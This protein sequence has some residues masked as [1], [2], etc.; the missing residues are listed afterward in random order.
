MIALV[1]L[2]W[3]P[4]G[5]A[6]VRDFCRS[7]DAHPAGAEHELVIALNGL[8]APGGGGEAFRLSLE[9]E[10][11]QIPHR[12]SVLRRP[13]LDL[14]AYGILARELESPRLCFLNSYS[15]ILADGWL[16]MLDKALS[17]PGVGLA[18]ATGSW[19]SQS[20]WRRGMRRYWLYQIL[21]L[22]RDRR[23]Y[24][25]F[26]NPHPRT[27]GFMIERETLLELGLEGVRDK[28][29]AYMLESGRS[30]IA[31]TLAGRGLTCVVVGRDGRIYGPQEW[32]E[33]STYRS[34]G[35][36]NL[37]IS[38][39]RT[40]EWERSPPRLKSR[41]ALDAWGGRAML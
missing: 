11:S 36:R 8:Q 37:L 17:E 31:P 40:R 1:H 35:Q 28:L 22:P 13:V 10:L 9:E 39:N 4:L 33:S 6:P 16:A 12:L 25:R 15:V 32:P 2:V 23:R 18:G 34:G 5:L 30:G 21:R 14:A 7:Y 41:L 26:P 24:P 19:E 29:D 27:A 3:A 38:D 20:E